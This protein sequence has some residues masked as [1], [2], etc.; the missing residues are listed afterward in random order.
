[1]PVG[2]WLTSRPRKPLALWSLATHE[3]ASV[4]SSSLGY[5][6]LLSFWSFAPT[7]KRPG[8]V[9]MVRSIGSGLC[10]CHAEHD[11]RGHC[12][13]FRMTEGNMEKSRK[14]KCYPFWLNLKQG[15]DLF[16]ATASPPK[17]VVRNKRYA[18]QQERLDR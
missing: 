15:Y 17:V 8:S 2:P 18:F 11:F 6:T 7:P 5:V 1:M 9:G 16:E 3:P 12:F 14:A 13:P 10:H 4:F